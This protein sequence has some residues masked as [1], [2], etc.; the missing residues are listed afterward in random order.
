[1]HNSVTTTLGG[2]YP[3]QLFDV[4]LANPPFAGTVQTESILSDLNHG[5]DKRST[6]LLFCKWFIDH[7]K[8]SG[9]AGV[10]VPQGVLTG[11]N[12]AHKFLRKTLLEEN[13]N[14]RFPIWSV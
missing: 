7:L 8:D 2:S 10:I 9:R 14:S 13:R 6:E 4:I 11:S 5:L 3:G 1:M 12:K